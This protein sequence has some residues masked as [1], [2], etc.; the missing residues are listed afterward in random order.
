MYTAVIACAA[1]CAWAAA[2]PWAWLAVA[3][4]VAVLVVKAQVEER[5]MLQQH[6]GY[7]DYGA[8]TRRFLPFIV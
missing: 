5:W 7:A 6:P 8:R 2:S 1:A 3:A 4:L